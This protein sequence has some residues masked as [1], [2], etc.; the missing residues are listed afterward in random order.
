MGYLMAVLWLSLGGFGASHAAVPLK[1]RV[2][3]LALGTSVSLRRGGEDLLVNAA[4]EFAFATP[5]TEGSALNLQVIAQPLGQTCA[6]SELAPSTVPSD[7][8]PIFVRCFH[9][10]G[11]AVQMP[12]TLPDWPL[13]V[14]FGDSAMRSVAYPGLP[15]ESRPGVTGGQFPYEFRLVAFTRDGQA[16]ATDGVRVDFRRGTVRFTPTSTGV[17]VVTVEIR[18]SGN[19]RKTVLRGFTITCATTPFL[20]VSPNGVDATGRGGLANP[21][22]TIAFALTQSS[23]QQV[24]VLRQGTYTGLNV[25]LD[26]T[27]ARQLIAYPDE[28][29]LLD[30]AQASN[31][32]VAVTAAPSARLEGLDFTR[33]QQYGIYSET[34]E[35]GL[36]V[37]H[38]RFRDGREN[39]QIISENPGFIHARGHAETT[40]RH[41]L[42]VQDSSFGPMQAASSTPYAATLFDVGESLFENNDVR[43]GPDAGGFHDK[44]NSQ[45]NT[46]RENYFEYTAATAN[47]V[48]VH[49]SA[50]DG[51]HDMHIHHNLF[52]YS[53][54][55]LGQQCFE[56]LGCRM[57]NMDV[58]HNTF[59]AGGIQFFVGA[60]NAN[61]AGHRVDANIIRSNAEAP[62]VWPVCWQGPLGPAITPRVIARRNRLETTSSL[63]MFDEQCSGSDANVPWATWQGSFGLDTVAQGSVLSAT[64]ALVGEG[65]LIGLPA[66]DARRPAL[67]HLYTRPS[68]AVDGLFADGFE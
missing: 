10:V 12:A 4:G 24:L 55:R 57:T 2:E 9:E 64:S 56:D 27:R 25:T 59:V 66:T 44:D 51:G 14:M 20:F 13:Q 45:F 67:G 8:A 22:R 26:N 1:V 33:V 42:L 65:P 68:S 37:R 11:P 40:P 50:Q 32:T 49:V 39:P 3:G 60:F 15:Y 54:V 19:P 63:A 6:L 18:D 36:I 30:F 58:H 48:G 47:R 29:A 52:V 17:Y 35:T 28:V 61:S 62:Y 23:P 7:S 46:Y 16:Q 53:G 38:A 43:A 5:A 21:F 31:I 34:A 41:R